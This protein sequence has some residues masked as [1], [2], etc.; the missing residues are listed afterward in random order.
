MRLSPAWRTTLVLFVTQ[1]LASAAFIATSTVGAIT[2]AALSGHRGWA[3]LPAA[4]SG[5]AG[6]GAAFA[7]GALMDRIGRRGALALGILCGVGGAALSVIAVVSGSFPLFLTGMVL[8]GVANAAVTL[9]RFIAADAHAADTRGRALAYVVLG[10]TAG[11][12]GGPLLVGPAGALATGAG[13]SQLAGAFAAAVILLILA[14]VVVLAA[15]RPA[16]VASVTDPTAAPEAGGPGAAAPEVSRSTG[17]GSAAAAAPASGA[18]PAV[19][20]RS[21][22]A[23]LRGPAAGAAVAAMVLSQVVM[24]GVMVIT[25]LHMQDMHHGLAD[26]SFVF[27]AHTIG[28]YAFSLLSGRLIDRWGRGQTIILG[29]VVLIIAC[30]TAPLSGKTFPLAVSLLL[31]GLGW[32]FCFVGGSTLLA[33][34]LR[35]AERG[36]TQGFNDLLVGLASAAG[37]LGSGLLSAGYGYAGVGVVGAVLS[38]LPLVF[39]A[40]W[41]RAARKARAQQEGAGM[42]GG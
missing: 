27:S 11:A 19:Q 25:S 10:G 14:G 29:A 38:L 24:V 23:I 18:P 37:S 20:P 35:A 15:L 1:C 34:Q 42:T 13:T 7:W 16:P 39:V 31:L 2:A 28:M 36:R 30:V 6:A 21:I 32:N 33:D 17:P 8:I 3:G 40:R 9:S 4:A 12:I 22:P 5:L 26:I 41:A